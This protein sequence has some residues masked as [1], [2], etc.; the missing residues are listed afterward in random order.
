MDLVACLFV[1]VVYREGSGGL[2]VMSIKTSLSMMSAGKFV[3]KLKCTLALSVLLLCSVIS[4]MSCCNDSS[5]CV[6][7]CASWSLHIGT[8]LCHHQA[9]PR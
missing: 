7:H 5:I 2:R 6:A 9:I 1:V 8:L 4:C 3:D